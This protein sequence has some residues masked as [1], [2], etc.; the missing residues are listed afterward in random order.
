MSE[1]SGTRKPRADPA[2]LARLRI[3]VVHDWLVTYAGAER[4]LE[5]ML[6]LFPHADV[7]TTV[8]LLPEDSRGFLGN[9][10]IHTS[11]LDRLP[12][13][14]RRHRTLLPLMPIAVEQFDLSRY[15]LVI[16]S[17]HAVAKGVLTGPDQMHISYCH[18]PIR[19]AWDLQHE[20]LRHSGMRGLKGIIARALLHYVRNWDSR[21]ANGVDSFVAN[22]RFIARRVYKTY[23]R[24]AAVI[25][26][27]VDV[28]AFSPGDQRGDFYLTASRMVPYK[29]M[30]L[31]VEAFAKLPDRRLVVIGD[32]PDMAR[33]RAA[34]GPNVEILGY[35]PDDAL[36]DYLR[37][38]RAFIFAAEE[39]FGILPVEAQACGTPVIAYGAG[40]ALET[41]I[42]GVTGVLFGQPSA[43]AIA[44]AVRSFEED[45]AAFCA[46]AIR[47]NAERFSADTFRERF[48]DFVAGEWADW[49]R[50]RE[51]GTIRA[52]IA[53]VA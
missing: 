47:R 27:P 42:D 28:N 11:F 37:R 39:D 29:R 18:S 6:L 17:S 46:A 5:Q 20:Y 3:A 7:F 52:E 9:A 49:Q 25:Y 4:V 48:L 2:A 33:V 31:I 23:R 13:L 19:Y 30:P 24:H 45:G 22:S 26:P 8:D 35:Q 32:G 10:T 34:A 43:S 12:L 1:L 21:T 38:A 36:R 15:N 16:S 40:G 44:D 53:R 41:V 50:G 14:R 51:D